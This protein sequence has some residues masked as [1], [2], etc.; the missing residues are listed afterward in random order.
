MAVIESGSINKINSFIVDKK[1]AT[2]DLS[3]LDIK[4]SLYMVI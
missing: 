1:S 2:A 4:N 3:L